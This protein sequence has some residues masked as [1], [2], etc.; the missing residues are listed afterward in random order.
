MNIGASAG[1]GAATARLFA[2]H[3][4]KLVLTGRERG[5]LEAVG[6]ECKTLGLSDKQVRL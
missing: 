6:Q 3:G 1:I 4:A 5:R 2:K